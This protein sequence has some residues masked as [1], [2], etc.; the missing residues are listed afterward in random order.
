MPTAGGRG[1]NGTRR[2]RREGLL[3]REPEGER[4]LREGKEVGYNGGRESMKDHKTA[5]KEE[6]VASNKR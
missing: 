2:P 6:K 5:W 3:A 1:G 4:E